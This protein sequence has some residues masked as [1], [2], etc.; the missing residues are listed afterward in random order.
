[1]DDFTRTI[2]NFPY[3]QKLIIEGHS[4]PKLQYSLLWLSRCDLVPTQFD[5]I[6]TLWLTV[7][8]EAEAFGLPATIE[9]AEEINNWIR[10]TE[11][12]QVIPYYDIKPELVS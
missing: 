4:S 8:A 7:L 10:I 3:I 6:T 9:E 12:N 2:L 5:L 1:M 11:V